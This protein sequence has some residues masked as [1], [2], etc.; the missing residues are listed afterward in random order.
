MSSNCDFCCGRFGSIYPASSQSICALPNTKTRRVLRQL[1][2]VSAM[3]CVFRA[4]VMV[5]KN[6]DEVLAG[7]NVPVTNFQ[8]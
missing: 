4:V 2:S 3:T 1:E 8:Q 6:F 5:A 7:I